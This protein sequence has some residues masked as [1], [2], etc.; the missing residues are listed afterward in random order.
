ML[1]FGIVFLLVLVVA[2]I[3][4]KFG[5]IV[6]LK[7]TTLQYAL[8]G[9]AG[10]FFLNA[11][12]HRNTE[13]FQTQSPPSVQMCEVDR[14]AILAPFTSTATRKT[15][16][17]CLSTNP[18]YKDPKFRYNYETDVFDLRCVKTRYEPGASVFGDTYS[19]SWREQYLESRKALDDLTKALNDT[20][21]KPECATTFVG[22]MNGLAGRR[23]M[24]AENAKGKERFTH[25]GA[26]IASTFVT[27]AA[28]KLLVFQHR[29]P[30]MVQRLV[31]ARKWLR[32]LADLVLPERKR[33]VTNSHFMYLIGE[34]LLAVLDKDTE[35]LNRISNE[36]VQFLM[37]PA[38]KTS[39]RKKAGVQDEEEADEEAATDFE[40]ADMGFAG[41]D[42][43]T[44]E[45]L[46]PS[47]DEA[48]G[49][50]KFGVF[51]NGFID[52]EKDRRKLIG[53]YNEYFMTFVWVLLFIFKN[54]G[55][56]FPFESFQ[57]HVKLVTD[58]LTD[59]K[60][61][62]HGELYIEKY[63]DYYR[64]VYKVNLNE[65][66]FEPDTK[67]GAYYSYLF[68]NGPIPRQGALYDLKVKERLFE[69]VL[70]AAFA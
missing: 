29:N 20:Y 12:L 22:L 5:N 54:T 42:Y 4:L 53:H 28:A 3:I 31:P 47:L 41:M 67:A 10:L 56:E 49:C 9:F 8:L 45:G 69:E 65:V 2:V 14:D 70:Q 1:R 62:A 33:Q 19:G 57:P 64:R 6:R 46:C 52:S 38:R 30:S 63:K 37:T 21:L 7:D 26:F 32:D 15:K 25:Q 50:P 58:V 44:N 23:A 48:L 66:E 43:D 27:F 34:A 17:Y 40:M 35:S 36:T 59:A 18:K 61:N 68:E 55:T 51:D 11:F 13:A 16:P 39:I 60:N 24:L